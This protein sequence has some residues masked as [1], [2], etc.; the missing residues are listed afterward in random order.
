MLTVLLVGRRQGKAPADSVSGESPFLVRRQ[1]SCLCPH[2]D[3]AQ[4]LCGVPN[5]LP[6]LYPPISSHRGLGFKDMNFGR[7][8][9]F[10]P[11]DSLRRKRRCV[12]QTAADIRICRLKTP[13]PGSVFTSGTRST[14][15]VSQHL[16]PTSASFV[17]SLQQLFAFPC[18]VVLS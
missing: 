2:V 18:S 14:T 11:Q 17:K 5:H 8:Q 16:I 6:E 1:L 4:E 12:R 3:T 13:F 9:T 15:H 7:A 10:R